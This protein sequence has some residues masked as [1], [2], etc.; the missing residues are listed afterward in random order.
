MPENRLV[1]WRWLRIQSVNQVFA[2]TLTFVLLF[3]ALA[4]ALE[5]LLAIAFRCFGVKAFAR[6]F[7]PCLAI[8]DLNLL[9]RSA[10]SMT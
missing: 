2:L 8:S 10:P 5:A 1:N 6:A 4:A 3:L 9:M 7:P